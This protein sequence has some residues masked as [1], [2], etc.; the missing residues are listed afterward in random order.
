MLTTGEL[1]VFG[2]IFFAMLPFKRT[3]DYIS[4]NFQYF[5]ERRVELER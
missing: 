3:N 1:L 2:Y 4:D 5:T